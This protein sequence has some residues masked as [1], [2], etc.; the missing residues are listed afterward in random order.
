MI[1]DQAGNG[2]MGLCD[3]RRRQRRCPGENGGCGDPRRESG[4]RYEAFR[5]PVSANLWQTTREQLT[6]NL[7]IVRRSHFEDCRSASQADVLAALGFLDGK[8]KFTRG[9][10]VFLVRVAG[11]FSDGSFDRQV[12]EDISGLGHAL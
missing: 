10:D 11:P 2:R 5:R 6:D 1:R 3:S 7:G 4:S 12:P 9:D 8:V